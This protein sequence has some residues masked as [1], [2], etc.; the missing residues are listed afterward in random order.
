MTGLLHDLRFAFRQLH[1]SAGFSLTAV[2]MLALGICANST[3]FSWINGTMLH[4]VPGARDTGQL[5]TVMRG[6]W[7]TSPSPPLSYHD[8]RDLREQNHSFDG[9]LAYHHEWYAL[10]AGQTPQRIYLGNV[11]ANF[12]DVLGIKP[13]L[14][15]FFR[16]DEEIET[17]GT[18]YV[19]LSY[20]MWQTNF[21]GDR[22]IVGKSIE[23]VRHQVTV[24]GVAPPGFIGA[25]PGIRDD[26]WAPLDP[27]GN[28][29][30][31]KHRDATWL[32]VMG[33][34]RPGVSR[35]SANQD[36]ETIMRRI[37]AQYPNEHLGVNTI[38]LD[39]LWRS[40]FGANGYV[41]AFLP[42]LLAIAGFVLLLTCANVATLALVRF[43]SRRREIAI[44]EALGAGRAQLMRQMILEGM[45]V[46]L[47]GGAI[48]VLLTAWTGK[49]FALFLPPSS[50]PIALNG[51]VDHNVVLGILAM[52]VIAG[53]L[54]GVL[55]AWRSSHVSAAE[56]L[57]E[58]AGAI[59]AGGHHRRL[60]SGLVVAQIGL[61]LALLVA[62]GLFLRTLTNMAEAD[63]G[64]EQDHVLNVSVGLSMAGYPNNEIA[65]I[66]HK[67]M[68]RVATLPGVS[69][70]AL[71]DWVPFSFTRKTVDTYPEGYAP[72]PHESLEVRRAE[73][74][75]GYFASMG[76]PLL[77]GREFTRDDIQTAPRVVIL[78]QTA[79]HRYF[80]GRSP[81]GKRLSIYGGWYTVVGVVRNSKHQFVNEPPEPMIYMSFFQIPDWETIVQVRTK[82]DPA[83]LTPAVE[84]AIRQVNAAY[85]H[86]RCAAAARDHADLQQLRADGNHVCHG[87]CRARADPGG[88][89]DLWSGGVPDAVAHARDRH[90]GG[91]RSI[92]R[93][94]PAPGAPPGTAPDRG[95]PVRRAR[96][97]AGAYAI[98]ARLALRGQRHRS[99]DGRLRGGG[100]R[101]HRRTGQLPSG[102]T[103]YAGEPGECHEGPVN[104]CGRRPRKAGP[105]GPNSH[106]VCNLFARMQ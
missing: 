45:L 106:N 100:A 91:T 93:R 21:G 10:T 79:A 76:I 28:A 89:G 103:G 35:E 41:S 12:F 92:A 66:Q 15:R 56:V 40:P 53:V 101:S 67:M 50:N 94:R 37:V 13:Y 73:V 29:E 70:A 63:P 18:P 16:P 51:T 98:P 31:M 43:V 58:E 62:A 71:T 69:V 23:I 75:E 36:L 19:V 102:A 82:G 104:R 47:G 54:C 44:R 42:L 97:V 64:F 14:G 77:E 9:I 49:T 96:A 4:P 83:T 2:I 25:M 59:S 17:S 65:V 1:K 88:N 105:A 81:V 74:S 84:Q 85:A 8:Y 3:V 20:S 55:P 68:D 61:S 48:A 11:S 90:P 26:A 33:R 6:A 5:V 7:T 95:R 52:A 38:T 24:I 30:H 34:L 87:L 60:L 39:P 80:P 57:K 86:L 72:K 99:R 27:M 78:D 22:A 32:N 46:S